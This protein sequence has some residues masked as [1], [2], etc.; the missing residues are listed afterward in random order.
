MEDRN[1][2]IHILGDSTVHSLLSVLLSIVLVVSAFAMPPSPD[3]IEQLREEGRLQ[4]WIDL[5]LDANS[6]GVNAPF[7]FNREQLTRDDRDEVEV[8]AVCILVDF[9]DNEANEDQFSVDHF[10]ELLFS[11]GEYRTGS[12]RDWYLENS[13]GEVH[14]VGQ[15]YGWYRMPQDYAYYVDGQRGMGQYPQ[16]AQRMVEDALRMA[17]EI[18]DYEDFDNGNNGVVEALFIVHAGQGAEATG[19]DDMIHSHAWGVPRGFSADGVRFRSYAMEPDD[20]K[21]GVFGHELGHS[22]FGL[23]DLY[24]TNYESRGLGMWSMMS[25]GSWG[26]G[27]SKPVHFDAWSKQAI[28]FSVPTPIIRNE[29][30]II[31]EPIE[32]ADDQ[33]IVWKDGDWRDEYFL[34]EN[35]QAVGFDE[36]LPGSGILI[37]HV[38]EQRESN[39][40]PWWPG[41]G[42]QHNKVALEQADGN[43]SLEHNQNSG[44]AS[45]P[46]PGNGNVNIFATDTEPDSRDYDLESTN[47]AVYYFE[48][49]D[50]IRV[51]FNVSIT[52][53]EFP[54]PFIYIL[55]KIP[56]NHTYPHP[57]TDARNDTR[58][59]EL[60]MDIL[61]RYELLIDDVGSELPDDLSMYNMLIYLESWREGDN[62]EGGLSIEEQEQLIQYLDEGGNL[63][64]VGPDVATNLQGDESP[65]WDYLGCDYEGEGNPS[66]EGNISILR[67]DPF[68]AISS[69]TFPYWNQESCDHYTDI[70]GPG[71]NAQLL[72]QDRDHNSRGFLQSGESG[73]RVIF[74][75]F[76]FGGLRDWGGSK[77]ELIRLYFS[78]FRF[79]LDP[80]STPDETEQ[81]QKFQLLTAYPNPFNSTLQISYQWLDDTRFIDVYDDL[82]RKVGQLGTP[83]NSGNIS[84]KPNSLSSG[85]YYLMPQN[86]QGAIPQKVIYLK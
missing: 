69:Q 16:N 7:E 67:S 37:W 10:Q 20:G 36:S 50:S 28:G 18:I 84:W 76:L 59:I 19:D 46:F 43:Y 39:N 68:N 78:Y 29:D 34:I 1:Y 49:V 66:E 22:Y 6:R 26:G 13:Y 33:L 21:I 85:S 77:A 5:E 52:P 9:D 74:Q 4:Q 83:Y 45:D 44:D 48:Q 15:V 54:D 24:D 86:A 11:E 17:D 53:I 51:K 27:G 35:R 80:L 40:N 47:V 70:V 32:L 30:N 23:P 71:E 60:V 14:V 82:G 62:A 38:D 57:D 41:Q 75:P 61:D 12:M 73:Y 79:P 81:P 63:I 8:H 55:N 58:E 72:F 65:L 42:G 3:I 25:G 2:C 31:L 64:M 56:N